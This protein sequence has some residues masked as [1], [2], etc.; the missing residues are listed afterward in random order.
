MCCSDSEKIN[1]PYIRRLT[2]LHCILSKFL[3]FLNLW[4]ILFHKKS[5]IYSWKIKLKLK[6]V[7][8]H[9][10]MW[11]AHCCVSNKCEGKQYNELYVLQKSNLCRMHEKSRSTNEGSSGNLWTSNKKNWWRIYDWHERFKGSSYI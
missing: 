8:Y 11:N 6:F 7:K 4:G 3:I 2:F 1:R 5:E 10:K 9:T